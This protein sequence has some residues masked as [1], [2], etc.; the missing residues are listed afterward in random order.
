MMPF[1]IEPYNAWDKTPKKKKHWHEII[2]EEQLMARIIA[3]Q[4]AS[5][6]Q[7]QNIAVAAAGAGGVPPFAY[8]NNEGGLIA[9]SYLPAAAAAPVTI[10]FT[11]TTPTQFG[12]ENTYNWVFGDGGTS[13]LKNPVH[14]YADTGSFNVELQ[15]T[16]S[17]GGNNT[18]ASTQVVSASNPRVVAAWTAT[19]ASGIAPITVS[20]TNTSTNNSYQPTSSYLWNF[21]N[22]LTST[23]ATLTSS[24]A[25]A[26][27]QS[28]AVT[29]RH[30]GSYS[31]SLFSGSVAGVAPTIVAAFT[32]TT[33]SNIAPASG[34]YVNTSTDNSLAR[35]YRWDVGDGSAIE[36]T[37]IPAPHIFHTGSFTSSLFITSSH[38]SDITSSATKSF[39][40]LAPTVTAG[41]ITQSYG[42]GGL[43]DLFEPVSMSF[44][45]STTH[46]GVGTLTYLWDF[47]TASFTNPQGVTSTGT[48]ASVGPH[49]RANYIVGGYTASLRVTESFY[50]IASIYTQSFVVTT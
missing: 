16:S 47:G 34:T 42:Q 21:N 4:Q 39:T 30:T 5:Q 6:Q 19:S 2:E 7:I 38:Y 3:E 27:T 44:T 40:L 31:A 25:F 22:G 11:N 28:Y 26:N 24:V 33:G 8:F 15:V 43:A 10:T 12:E 32:L 17:L 41:M 29:L 48:S 45:S 49:F 13:T 1:L 37:V 23:L 46:D 18:S 14:F 20:F 50:G 9:F 35:I 36:T